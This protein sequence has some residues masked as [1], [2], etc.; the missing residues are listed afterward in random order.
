MVIILGVGTPT[1]TY[2]LFPPQE[3]DH[4]YLA[5]LG[6]DRIPWPS[7][8]SSKNNGY[9]S[10][11]MYAAAEELLQERLI[12]LQRVVETARKAAEVSIELQGSEI[13]FDHPLGGPNSAVRKLCLLQGL[14]CIAPA[15]LPPK[16]ASPDP[17]PTVVEP[18]AGSLDYFVP[19]SDKSAAAKEG[20][21]I[22]QRS[23]AG[24]A[25]FGQAVKGLYDAKAFIDA[26]KGML[27][28]ETRRVV[29]RL[30]VDMKDESLKPSTGTG[31]QIESIMLKATSEMKAGLSGATFTVTQVSNEKQRVVEG[32]PTEWIWD[33][34]ANEEGQQ[35]LKVSFF[36]ILKTDDG[37]YEKFFDS[38]D[39]EIKVDIRPE[40]FLEEVQKWATMLTATNTLLVAGGGA[41]STILTFSFWGYARN[42]VSW[43][44]AKKPSSTAIVL[45]PTA[46]PA[47]PAA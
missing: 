12:K 38:K 29:V 30:G 28:K 26:P 44:A 6:P 9:P 15:I 45:P 10:D 20:L 7:F 11:Q 4:G 17:D 14:S 22:A 35:T 3:E 32:V 41:I 40:T 1:F 34:T 33:V 18:D 43:L 5:E 8:A 46:P 31:R 19:T 2:I 23:R 25:E 37:D 21:K 42:F 47:G 16:P 13:V 36:I 24:I 27:V 39:Q